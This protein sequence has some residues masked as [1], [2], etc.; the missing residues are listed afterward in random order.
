MNKDKIWCIYFGLIPKLAWP[1]QIYEVSLTKVET[2]ERLISKF[3]KKWLGVPDSL[4]NV[5]L[6]SSSTKRK[7]PTLSLVEEYKL[8]KARLSQMLRDS[9]DPMVKNAQASM[10]TGRKW[11]AKIAVANAKSALK[12][13]EIIGTVANV[14]VGLGL[15]PQCW[16][17]KKST[18]N[19]RKKVSEEIHHL[20]EVRRFATAVG[21]RKQGVWTKW[22]N[23]KDRAVTWRDLKHMEQ[24]KL[25]FLIKAVYDVLPTAVNLH[26]WGL[27]TSNRCSACGKTASLKHILTGCEYALSSYTWRHNEV[28]GIFSEVSKTWCKTA[29]K[30]LNIINNRAIQF[31]KEGNISKTA[32][33]NMRKPSLLEGCADWH[34]ATDLKH[35][36]IFPTEIELMT[37][38][39]DIV[40]WSVKAKK[41]FRYWVNGPLWRKFRLGTSA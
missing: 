32:R 2:M 17:S 15:H 41:V 6:Y 26:A 23:V 39:P 27:T 13:K 10:I 28:L 25:S 37:K 31:I 18:A 35:N 14:K 38:R 16:W 11:K 12:M 22:E 8:G 34:V 33:E 1:L 30:A 4:T 9:R 19:R 24:K 29:N 36:F 40:I 7:L 3:I 20:E 5:A 21:Q